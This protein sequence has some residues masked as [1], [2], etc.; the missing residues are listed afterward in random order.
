MA[1]KIYLEIVRN[2]QTRQIYGIHQA[3]NIFKAKQ[4]V[5]SSDGLDYSC[6]KFV[7]VFDDKVVQGFLEGEIVEIDLDT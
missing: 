1:K 4:H 7:Q 6:Y 5:P 3:I 2:S